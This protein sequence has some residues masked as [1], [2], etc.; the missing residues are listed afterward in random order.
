MPDIHT[1]TSLPP[2]Y[3]TDIAVDQRG[4]VRV[5]GVCVGRRITEGERILFEVKDRERSRSLARGA[6]L[7]RVDVT[8]LIARLTGQ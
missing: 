5:G 1:V 2:L 6:Q 4:F 7:I 8:E 3:T